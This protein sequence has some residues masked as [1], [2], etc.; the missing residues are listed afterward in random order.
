MLVFKKEK[1]VIK[2]AERYIASMVECVASAR[3]A[4]QCY[5]GEM[6]GEP[7]ELHLRVR[8]LE[9][10]ADA[11]RLEIRN[12]LYSGAY[13]PL[14]REDI[15][16]VIALLDRVANAAEAAC[17]FVIYQKPDI[18]SML[19]PAFKEIL[20]VSFGITK[21]LK[22]GALGYFEPKGKM[23]AIREHAQEV[24]RQES[25]VDEL[26][27]NLTKAIFDSTQLDLSRKLHLQECLNRITAVSDRAE[28]AADQLELAALKSVV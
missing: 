27:S 10:S 3:D 23:D 11:I 18:P 7:E 2:L 15:H 22:K 4:I 17:D 12:T 21:P 20:K 6:D 28:N 25:K 16:K 13:V 26:E 24:G 1:K 5:L 19:H 9:S 8:H 14:I